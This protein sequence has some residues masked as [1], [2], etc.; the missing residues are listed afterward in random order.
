MPCGLTQMVMSAL[1]LNVL[2]LPLLLLLCL[3]LQSIVLQC[4]DCAG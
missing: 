2:L 1:K 4:R 3:S